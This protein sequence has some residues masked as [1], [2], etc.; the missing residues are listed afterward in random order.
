MQ[1]AQQPSEQ[2]RKRSGNQDAP[3]SKRFELETEID[4]TVTQLKD[5]HGDKYTAP[6]MRMWARY[7]QAGHYKD[8]VE[9]LPL[10][11]FKGIPPKRESLSD[12]IAGAAVTFVNAI[13]S[14]E[15]KVKTNN[16]VINAQT[17]PMPQLLLE[18]PLVK[19]L[20]FV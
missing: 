5:I 1:G 10:P 17:P 20:T 14:P 18:S 15:S 13:R 3:K 6:Q 19:P 8:L 2:K 12:T 4:D 16:V 7:I 11:A 9:P